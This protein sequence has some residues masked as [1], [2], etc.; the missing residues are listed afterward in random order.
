MIIPLGTKTLLLKRRTHFLEFL[1]H[2]RTQSRIDVYMAFLKDFCGKEIYDIVHNRACPFLGGDSLQ[3]CTD[4]IKMCY[5]P[6]SKFNE[7]WHRF[8]TKESF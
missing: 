5:A 2:K 4:P 3:E 1:R 6:F 8:K 7:N